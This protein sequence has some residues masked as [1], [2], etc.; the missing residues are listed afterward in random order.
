MLTSFR[1]ISLRQVVD[2][3]MPFLFRLF[4]DPSRSHL[5]LRGRRVYD[6]AGF[7][8]AWSAWTSDELAGKFIVESVQRPIGL[9]FDHDRTTEDGWTKATTL[10]TEVS[11]GHG[12]GVVAT[13]L[14]MDWLFQVL[15]FRKIYHD[16]FAYNPG[17]VRMWRKL[18]LVEEGVLK[19]DRF[20]NGVYWDQHIFALYRE[21]WTTQ[22]RPRILRTGRSRRP[23][24]AT[25]E[26]KEV[27]PTCEFPADQL[28]EAS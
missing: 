9:V 1:G 24:A 14:F 11:M 19:A 8:R 21:S 16:V 18:G 13:A 17:V 22:I 5:W 12:A 4:A 10:L 25:P 7:E 23:P 3:D 27:A 15:P 20:W 2:A 6:E 26:R 28:Q